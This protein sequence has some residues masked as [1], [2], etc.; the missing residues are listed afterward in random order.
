MQI[1]NPGDYKGSGFFRNPQ[2]KKFGNISFNLGNYFTG[3][4]NI[5]Y[6][7]Q[8]IKPGH[9]YYYVG[10][11][12]PGTA[13]LRATTNPPVNYQ[14]IS[15]DANE[16][17]IFSQ[18]YCDQVNW[19]FEFQVNLLYQAEFLMSLVAYETISLGAAAVYV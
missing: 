14:Y 3:F 15:P 11:E 13:P 2:R 9:F 10:C 1:L 17:N 4:D 18:R 6:D 7:H 12:E 19:A 16:V 8:V 5:N